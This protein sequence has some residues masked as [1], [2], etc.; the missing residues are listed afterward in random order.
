MATCN[1]ATLIDQ[2]C[3]NKFT[4]LDD[5]RIARGVILQLLCNLSA[6]GGSA[7]WGGITGLLS[8]QAD[9]QAALDAKANVSTTLIYRALLTQTG[10]NAPTAVILENTVG[11]IVWTRNAP[12]VY[13]GTLAGAFLQAKTFLMCNAGST[14]SGPVNFEY[15]GLKR[16]SDNALQIISSN[17]ND[18]EMISTPVEII[19]YP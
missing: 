15:S 16:I 19:I 4:C 18:D 7:V 6:A 11:V 14:S 17:Q 10:T 12:G 9:L 8:D 1:L 3:E 5:E 13:T 2:A